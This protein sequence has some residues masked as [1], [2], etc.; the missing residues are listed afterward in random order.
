MKNSAGEFEPPRG[1]R[2]SMSL[3]YLTD[4]SITVENLLGEA[5]DLH[6]AKMRKE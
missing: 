1:L 2:H 3:H 5:R 4:P 6:F